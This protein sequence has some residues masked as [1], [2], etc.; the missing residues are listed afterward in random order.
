M[1][2][3]LIG[4]MP[5]GPPGASGAGASDGQAGAPGLS[6]APEIT[7]V[8]EAELA[9]AFSLPQLLMVLHRAEVAYLNEDYRRCVGDLT[10][11]ERL[12]RART[13]AGLDA[14]DAEEWGALRRRAAS[15]A[16]QLAAGFD[17]YGLPKNHAPRVALDV[18]KRDVESL[19][20]I[21]QGIEETYEAFRAAAKG[22]ERNPLREALIQSTRLI[23]SLEAEQRGAQEVA[24]KAQDSAALLTTSLQAQ[25]AELFASNDALQAAI[26]RQAGCSFGDV[27]RV[28]NAVVAVG[29]AAYGDITGILGAVSSVAGPDAGTQTPEGVIAQVRKVAAGVEDLRAQ[30]GKV[31]DLLQERKHAAKLIMDRAEFDR[32]IEPYRALPEAQACRA[33]LDAYLATVD[34]INHM[35]VDQHAALLR[36]EAIAAEVAQRRHEEVRV[37]NTLAASFDGALADHVAFFGRL[38]RRARDLLCRA[39]HREFRAYQYW[40]LAEDRFRVDDRSVT[41]LLATQAALIAQCEDALERFKRPASVV[42]N[43]V[44]ALEEAE[45]GSEFAR[46]REG[47]PLT[48]LVPTT[49]D[50]FRE[51]AAVFVQDVAV[52]VPGA[53]TRDG[54]LYVRLVH[55]G[56]ATVVTPAHEAR[57]YLHESVPTL[58]INNLRD[59]AVMRQSL[60]GKEGVFAS[61]SP[62]ALWTLDLS[63]SRGL[64]LAAVHTIELDF[65]AT[66]LP[67]D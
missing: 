45:M 28:V 38:Y 66:F 33:R 2:R 11:I 24:R 50:A 12:A 14:A 1:S 42:H 67:F 10:W 18:Y 55:Q 22:A 31:K 8:G 23:A 5:P 62:F 61:V 30:Y 17:F 3:E 46:L 36:A 43:L 59:G 48:F 26:Q 9:S 16:S 64:D 58:L 63:A 40:A 32:A 29:R 41:S 47:R 6:F 27:L 65:T 19:G 35:L 49:H 20:S 44:V 57:E 25:E 54:R 51:L 52:R 4:R 13:E 34:T 39:L 56:R 21:A 60:G 37:R 53:A 15:L 7:V